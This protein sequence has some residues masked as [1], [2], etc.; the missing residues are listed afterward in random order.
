LAARRMFEREIGNGLRAGDR[1]ARRRRVKALAGVSAF[2]V[3][4]A[5]AQAA[6]ADTLVV[7]RDYNNYSMGTSS[8]GHTG[9]G[10]WG[11]VS[12]NGFTPPSAASGV[13]YSGNTFQTFCLERN[14]TLSPGTYTWTMSDSA[15]NGGVGG[16]TNNADPICAATA[17]LYGLFYSGQ[18][19][20]FGGYSY[21]YTFG[22]NRTASAG[23]LQDAIWLLED[24]LTSTQI[25]H[26]TAG[27]A[28]AQAAI[29][30]V[31]SSTSIGNVRVLTLTDSNGNHQDV[32]VM[33]PLP[34]A[35]LLGFGLMS[36][37]GAVGI[38]R[39]RKNHSV[40]A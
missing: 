24:E 4:L 31:G 32:L 12:I 40:L 38:L 20:N 30:A 39:R 23:E 3:A 16:A 25:N 6:Q 28:W 18:L 11:I 27:W 17:Y 8:S 1:N 13:T 9:G 10:E 21:N 19:T 22:S 36:A 35:A 5:A 14:E 37:V 26:S 34:S 2:V 15:H 33:V 29:S 7:A